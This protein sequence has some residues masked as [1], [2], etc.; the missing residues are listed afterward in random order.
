MAPLSTN[1]PSSYSST[2]T[3]FV[4]QVGGYNSSYA[5]PFTIVR[6]VDVLVQTSSSSVTCLLTFRD[7]WGD[8]YNNGGSNDA[9]IYVRTT[10]STPTYYPFDI[11]TKS[12]TSNPAPIG[13]YNITTTSPNVSNAG[14]YL[15]SACG[16]NI[17]YT[18]RINLPA[19]TTLVVETR[20]DDYGSEYRWSL[21]IV[22][23]STNK[24]ALSS[25]LSNTPNYRAVISASF[26][27]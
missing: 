14:V 10:T 27:V 7:T 20:V 1:N 26:T 9:G 6:D 4:L 24:A 23:G 13:F 5:G 19:S 16:Q 12:D 15:T 3:D 18:V 25:P 2:A 11:S 8:G 17:D 22:G 21:K